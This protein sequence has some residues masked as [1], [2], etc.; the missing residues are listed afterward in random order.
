MYTIS[1]VT[2]DKITKFIGLRLIMADSYQN[3]NKDTDGSVKSFT[4]N[5]SK[6]KMNL[7]SGSCTRSEAEPSIFHADFTTFI[8][9]NNKNIS[10][11]HSIVIEDD[12]LNTALKE[13]KN[14][15]KLA[16]VITKGKVSFFSVHFKFDIDIK[17]EEPVFFNMNRSLEC[18]FAKMYFEHLTKNTDNDIYH[19][20]DDILE[21][22]GL[23]YS[24]DKM[25]EIVTVLEMVAI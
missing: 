16:N 22:H 5:C 9:E 23:K 14:Y 7:L 19:I 13:A 8:H 15:L 12:E 10:L 18:M 17:K 3:N 11:N 21:N 24:A 4:I 2:L 1:N 20:I 25:T 6:Q